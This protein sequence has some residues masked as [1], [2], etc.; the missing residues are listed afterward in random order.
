MVTLGT[1]HVYELK[2]TGEIVANCHK[3]PQ[4]NFN[5]RLLTVQEIN[6]AFQQT[7]RIIQKQNPHVNWLFTVSPVRHVKDGLVENNLSK[8]ILIQSIAQ[9]VTQ[10]K[11]CQYFPAY[12]IVLD[13]LRDYRFYK[14]DMIHPND[15]A[16]NYIWRAFQRVG[17]NQA[18]I[19]F[20]EQWFKLLSSIRHKPLHVETKDHQV[21]LQA[22]RS[23][24]KELENMVDITAELEIIDA[25]IQE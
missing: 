14:E 22:T 4:Q 11:N 18:T 5:K 21:F 2:E 1:A 15:Q 8:S 25:Q 24:L 17:F 19:S 3:F 12:E 10:N 13:E 7:Y 20:C 6:N 23:K 9:M 16:V